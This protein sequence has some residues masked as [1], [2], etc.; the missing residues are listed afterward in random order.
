M[1]IDRQCCDTCEHVSRMKGPY[2]GSREYWCH[3]Q[4]GQYHENYVCFMYEPDSEALS[5]KDGE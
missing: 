2:M 4:N 3:K 1:E 5:R